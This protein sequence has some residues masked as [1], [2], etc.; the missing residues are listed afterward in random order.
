MHLS[1]D[2]HDTIAKRAYVRFTRLM[3]PLRSALSISFLLLGLLLPEN[4]PEW[5][6]SSPE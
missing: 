1:Q 2:E 6:F 3:P 4:D 5:P